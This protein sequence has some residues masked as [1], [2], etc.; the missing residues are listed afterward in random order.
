VLPYLWYFIGLFIIGI[1]V[2]C[3]MYVLLFH[4]R[5]VLTRHQALRAHELFV[6]ERIVFASAFIMGIARSQVVALLLFVISLVI[7][8]LSQHV[9]RER[10][11]LT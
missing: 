11:E 7:T 2:L 4:A 1:L 6:T 3:I 10:Y 9:L 5:K 8:L